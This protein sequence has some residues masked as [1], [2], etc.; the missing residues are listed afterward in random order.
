M[1]VFS[2]VSVV[3]GVGDASVVSCLSGT[4]GVGDA[5]VFSCLRGLPGWVMLVFSRVAVAT[6]ACLPGIRYLYEW[7]VR[8]PAN[9]TNS[10][11]GHPLIEKL[12]GL[13]TPPQ[14]FNSTPLNLKVCCCVPERPGHTSAPAGP[15]PPA[16]P[17]VWRLLR[18]RRAP[19]TVRLWVTHVRTVAGLLPGAQLGMITA[20]APTTS[21]LSS[22]ASTVA[23]LAQG[24][25]WADALPQAF[26]QTAASDSARG[27]KPGHPPW[28][29]SGL[30]TC[31]FYL[32]GCL[33][34]RSGEAPIA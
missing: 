22:I 21:Q 23:I 33:R 5:R 11:S 17:C 19:T 12:M 6:G 15:T 8:A 3:P 7:W 34:S 27:R 4:P 30:A 28:E 1:L 31:N 13:G 25:K 24:T 26:F 20:A 9:S 16:G 10:G 14:I 18:I 29:F 2:R 32:S